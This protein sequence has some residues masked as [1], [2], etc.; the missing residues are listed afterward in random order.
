MKNS[1][2]FYTECSM[3]LIFNIFSA[4]RTLHKITMLKF[5][6]DSLHVY[7][8][9]FFLSRFYFYNKK[10]SVVRTSNIQ[11]RHF[12]V[13]TLC[14]HWHRRLEFLWFFFCPSPLDC[15]QPISQ[16]SCFK[17]LVDTG[18]SQKSIVFHIQYCCTVE[19]KQY[20]S[21]FRRNVFAIPCEQTQGNVKNE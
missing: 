17:A 18:L 1:T 6:H 15:K 19:K 13:R 3:S 5:G 9:D 11:M 2:N 20:I 4:R 10:S 16:A 21:I 14:A 12:S 7:F 8:L